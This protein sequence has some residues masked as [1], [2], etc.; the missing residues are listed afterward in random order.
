MNTNLKVIISLDKSHD[1]PIHLQIYSRFKDAIESGLLKDGDRIPS[2]RSLASQLGVARGTVENAY[3]MLL[4]E[5]VFVSKGQ[6]GTYVSRPTPFDEAMN[7]YR[8]TAHAPEKRI[9]PQQGT[10]TAD[11]ISHVYLPGC[12]AFDAFPRKI[13]SRLTGKRTRSISV[14]EMR[15]KEPQGYAP[16]RRS[17]AA[18]LRLAR[19]VACEPEQIFV[20]NGYQG[21]LDFLSKVLALRGEHVWMEDPGYLLASMLL[22]DAGATLIRVPI[23]DEG[24][25]VSAGIEQAPKAKLAIVTPSHHS[26]LGLPMSTA[27]RTQLLDWANAHD[28]WIVEDDYDG[29]FRYSGYPLP[30]L[31]SLDR[32]DRVIYAGSFSK[33]IFP[34]L[35]LGYVVVPQSLVDA[36]A[37]KA[38]IHQRGFSITPQMIVNDFIAEGHFSRHLKK[39]RDLYAH[40]RE[41]TAKALTDILDQHLTVGSHK[42]GM[43]FV[44]SL[45]NRYSDADV[46]TNF[47]QL[48]YGIHVL[49]QWT[50]DPRHNGLIIGFT[51][52]PTRKVAEETALKLKR[53]L[54]A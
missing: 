7:S 41:I 21:A 16:L 17:I 38:F 40:R 39:M 53:C 15:L 30:S 23:D 46:A 18:Y 9:A 3:A 54:S 24:L 52:V 19:G 49:S 5:G 29:E 4:G 48:G 28:A 25:I 13:W 10:D 26:P 11:N 45:D 27:R 22:K 6:S 37:Q 35:K 8:T 43:H 33:T 1:H 36:C 47:N 42:N 2:T 51:N 32:F 34:A 12:P 50:V 44:A 14:E 20:T 31:K